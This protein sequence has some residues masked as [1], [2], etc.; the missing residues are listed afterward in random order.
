M[1]QQWLPLPRP[2]TH[3][4]ARAWTRRCE[5]MRRAGDGVQCAVALSGS[6]VLVGC[7]GLKRTDWRARVT[8]IG[9][10]SVPEHRGR[11]YI[12][13]A[14]RALARWAL[15]SEMQ[16]VEL[17]AA[18]GNLASNRVAVRAGFTY[19]GLMRNAGFV[20]GGRVDLGL[21]SL[22]PADVSQPA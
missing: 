13:E 4:D 19:E 10:W 7:V 6:D 1:T 12:T 14:V 16:R 2:Y 22:I 9:Y 3:E 21:Y 15:E 11:G 18:P 8:E 5:T 20:H 17:L